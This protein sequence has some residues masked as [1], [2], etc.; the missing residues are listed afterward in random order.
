MA[1]DITLNYDS[2]VPVYRQIY[3][4]ILAALAA[5][6][7]GPEDQLPTIHGLAAELD[8]NPNTVIRAYRELER[9]GHIRSER[10]RGTFPLAKKVPQDRREGA[11]RRVLAVALQE[12]KRQKLSASDFIRFIQKE[13]V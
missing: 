6:Q 12:C 3:E 13:L 1:L 8:I 4:A 10:G 11:F 9:A 5:N 7:L 2:G